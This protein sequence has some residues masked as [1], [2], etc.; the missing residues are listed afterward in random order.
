MIAIC[1]V[2]YGQFEINKKYNYTYQNNTKK[3]YVNGDYSNTEFNKRQFDVMFIPETSQKSTKNEK[4][5]YN[6]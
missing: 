4:N 6:F 2:D 5:L 3:Y 1:I